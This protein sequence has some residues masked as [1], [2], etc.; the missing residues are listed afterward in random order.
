LRRALRFLLACDDAIRRRGP[1]ANRK[2]STGS[3][4][5]SARGGRPVCPVRDLPRRSCRPR[6]DR[7]RS[8][9]SRHRPPWWRTPTLGCDPGARGGAPSGSG[10]IRG[11]IAQAG[12][13]FPIKQLSAGLSLRAGSPL[14]AA[15]PAARAGRRA[16]A[17]RVRAHDRREVPAPVA[18][19]QQQALGRDRAHHRPVP[20]VPTIAAVPG[21][22]RCSASIRRHSRARADPAWRT[23]WRP[24]GRA[25]GACA[26]SVRPGAAGEPG[27]GRRARR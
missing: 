25:R 2:L 18:V 24:R 15:C 12:Y 7:R 8:P 21:R 4:G 16:G 22:A 27:C 10:L 1:D 6:G 26:A 9:S 23:A 3:R 20:A 11:C 14:A 19:G 5:M 17:G 13:A